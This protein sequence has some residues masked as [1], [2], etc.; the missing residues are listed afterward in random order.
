MNIDNYLETALRE[1]AERR[2]QE[3]SKQDVIQWYDSLLSGVASEG[4]YDPIRD[5]VSE[6]LMLN[7]LDS[8]TPF[9]TAIQNSIDYYELWYCLNCLYDSYKY[10]N[11]SDS[12]EDSE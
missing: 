1:E 5:W 12:E 3:D 8:S 7:G 4:R 2:E 10:D 9:Y 11:Y 6:I